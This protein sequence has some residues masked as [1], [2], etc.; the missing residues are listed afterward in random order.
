M[1]PNPT[2]TTFM[3]SSPSEP[4]QHL[5]L[6]SVREVPDSHAWPAL[7]DHPTVYEPVPV[8]DLAGPDAS[9]AHLARVCESWGAFQVT[10][11]GIRSDLLERLESETRRLFAL[12]MDQKLKAARPSNG[13]SGYGLARISC[14]F[15]KLMWSEGFTISGSPLDHALKLWPD[16]NPS[17]FCD[18]MQECSDEMKQVAGRVVRLMLL[19]MG[20][21]PEEMKRAEE[22]TR[23]DQLSAVLQLN[24]YPPCPDPN[25]A[26]GLAAHTD[27]S[28]VT[29]LFQSG[30]SGL[31]L[32][33]RQDQ[34]GPAR[35]VTV[36]PRPGALI[37]LA[38]DLLQILTNGRYKSV[39]HRAVVNRNHHRVSV[40]YICGPPPHHKLS[41]VGKPA[42]PAP[43]LAYR[44]V[45]WADYLGL[46]AELFDKALA[47]IMVAEDSRGDEGICC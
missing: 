4:H 16:A 41:P 25:R 38:G 43:C 1:N 11:H 31:Q 36:P 20:L 7:D 3:L 18:V 15:S 5:E 42:S 14:F 6:E 37:V 29:L 2:T 28:L 24:S 22:G 21:T 35:W 23:V 30:T 40:A 27:S 34:H 12:P 33:R 17:R 44:A 8:V 32:L 9:V 13:I 46:K 26:M 45:S 19:S 47:S 10:G 39:A